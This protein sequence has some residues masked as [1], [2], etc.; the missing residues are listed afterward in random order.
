MP[1]SGKIRVTNFS[2]HIYVIAD[3]FGIIATTSS[4]YV[5]ACKKLD[6]REPVVLLFS[7]DLFTND[8]YFIDMLIPLLKH[9]VN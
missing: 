8:L 2:G 7:K 4:Q 6:G 9:Y 1:S 3:N 5:N